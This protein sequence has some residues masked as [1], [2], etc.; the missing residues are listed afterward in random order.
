MVTDPNH[1]R[2]A[3][4]LQSED[5][6]VSDVSDETEQ[7][8][9]V[10]GAPLSTVPAPNSPANGRRK[11]GGRKKKQYLVGFNGANLPLHG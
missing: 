5:I 6:V 1:L 3:D 7:P 8:A 11:S 2:L 9:P 10:T 4:V